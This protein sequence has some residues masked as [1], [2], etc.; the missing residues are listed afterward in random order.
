MAI[1]EARGTVGD[2]TTVH[3]GY[4]NTAYEEAKYRAERVVDDY[5]AGGFPVVIVS[6]GGVY[7]PG[8]V[9]PSVSA[10]VS[11]ANGTLPAM[12]PGA[13]SMVY[14]GDVAAGHLRAMDVGRPG[15]RYILSH[16]T[17]DAAEFVG[18]ACD[19]AGVERPPVLPL[20]VARV[21]ALL[22]EA[23]ARLTGRQPVVAR[24][25][26]EMLA[27]GLRLDGSKAVRELG[28]RYTSYDE[29]M[30]AG[31]RWYWEQGLLRRKPAFIV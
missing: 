31:L 12:I 5:A 13:L 11:A 24:D 4:F 9:T 27:H 2:E 6:P 26:I 19:L 30:R 20:P 17:M 1:G 7:G 25:T 21:V 28:V 18:R 16:E 10:V 23:G 15:E 14:V 29:G 22:A 3:R 8:G